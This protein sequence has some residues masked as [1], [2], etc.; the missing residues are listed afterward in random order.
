MALLFIHL[1]FF[2]I[3]Y[4]NYLSIIKN[5]TIIYGY[6]VSFFSVSHLWASWVELHPRPL[7]SSVW[8]TPVQLFTGLRKGIQLPVTYKYMQVNKTV[9]GKRYCWLSLASSILLWP[10]LALEQSVETV[11]SIDQPTVT[12]TSFQL[13]AMTVTRFEKTAVTVTRFELTAMTITSFDSSAV[14]IT[15][16]EQRAVTDTN[17][18]HTADC[19]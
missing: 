5:I 4:G 2:S 9:T 14:T 18:E 3:N 17:F 1:P 15:S 6:R 11:T 10:S 8:R 7:S 12:I 19:H 16:F 13:N